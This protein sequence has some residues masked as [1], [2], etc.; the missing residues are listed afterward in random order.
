MIVL[1]H[2]HGLRHHRGKVVG[3]FIFVGCVGQLREYYWNLIVLTEFMGHFDCDGGLTKTKVYHGAI[4]GHF[5]RHS[6]E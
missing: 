5:L 3:S 1:D 6:E 2:F 4:Q